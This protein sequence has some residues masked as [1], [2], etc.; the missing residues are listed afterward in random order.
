MIK[1]MNDEEYIKK[2]KKRYA[3]MYVRVEIESYAYYIPTPHKD[4][5]SLISRMEI[6]S[7]KPCWYRILQIALLVGGFVRGLHAAE[8]SSVPRLQGTVHCGS[9]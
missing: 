9:L 6:R 2:M 7:R 5:N 8:G 3:E 1:M 4:E